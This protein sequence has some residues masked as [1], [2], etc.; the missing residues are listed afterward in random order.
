MVSGMTQMSSS[1]DPR[2]DVGPPHEASRATDADVV[3]FLQWSLPRLGLRW[4]G[5]RN[6]RGTV[7]KR[8]VRRMAELGLRSLAE[9]RAH[10]EVADEEWA[11]LDA[12]CV[13][14]ISR[15]Y[16]DRAVFDRLAHEVLPER[17]D[18][19]SRE[20]RPSVRIWSAGCASGEDPYT[21]A[22]LWHLEIAPRHPGLR[23]DLVATDVDETMIT[24]AMRGCYGEGSLRELPAR[25][26]DAAFHRDD[27]IRIR[28]ELRQGVTF[29]REDMRVVMPDGPFDVIL[30]RNTAFTY[31]DEPT[32]RAVAARLITGLRNGGALVVGSHERL[33]DD[34][35]ALHCRGPS[36]YE[37]IDD[38][39]SVS[40]RSGVPASR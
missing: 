32:Q 31:F 8:L 37:R 16:R 10:L 11:V 21:V 34:F 9:Y 2:E 36:F 24:R 20:G 12:M 14:P 6:V 38:A 39:A 23:L 7:R 1:T 29:R 40:G 22:I 33:P 17:A 27:R 35:E 25:L 5:F 30:C 13:I 19:A 3:A 4:P 15:L 18:A 26:R 28:D